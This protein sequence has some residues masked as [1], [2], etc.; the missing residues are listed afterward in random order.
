M[1][2]TLLFFIPYFVFNM[3][4]LITTKI[5]LSSGAALCELNPFYRMLPFNE[6]LKII[7]PFFLLALCVFLYRLSR[8]EESRRKIG[9][10][11]ARCMLAI[12]ILFAAVTANNVCWLILSA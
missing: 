3:F 1:R 10:S 5:A 6:I 2:R 11:S 7:S 12:S 4:D 9:V 8:T